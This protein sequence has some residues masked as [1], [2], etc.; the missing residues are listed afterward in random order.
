MI[1]KNLSSNQ[2]SN[3]HLTQS[4]KGVKRSH[5]HHWIDR[6]HWLTVSEEKQLFCFYCL[7]FVR[8]NLWTKTGYSDLKHLSE[9]I[10]NH[11][12]FL[13]HI[14]NTVI[15][16][17][18]NLCWT[19]EFA[20]RG[21]DKMTSSHNRGI[22]LNLLEEKKLDNLSMIT[23]KMIVSKYKSKTFQ[24]ELLNCMFIVY[25]NEITKK[26]IMSITYQFKQMKQQIYH[27][28]LSL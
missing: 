3:F 6:K 17:K 19:H 22:F 16:I 13:K 4:K 15:T 9:R 8:D 25:Q 26:F 28:C 12:R 11:Q 27:V 23:R 21:H 5:F 18:N 7:L 24:N 1:V 20:L 2:P 10:G 14:D